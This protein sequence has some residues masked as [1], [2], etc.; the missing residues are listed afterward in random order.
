M[1]FVFLIDVSSSF[2]RLMEYCIIDAITYISCLLFLST[3]GCICIPLYNCLITDT[4]AATEIWK[5]K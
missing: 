3:V 4:I 2:S 1:A 5:K